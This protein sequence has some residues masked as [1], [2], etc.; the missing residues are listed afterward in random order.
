MKEIGGYEYYNPNPAGRRVGDCTVRAMCKALSLDW[1]PALMLLTAKAVEIYD[2]PSSNAV[3]GALLRDFGF[4]RKTIGV[5]QN[6]PPT[7]STLLLEHPCG[8]VVIAFSGHIATAVDG[9]IYDS[10]DSRNEIPL[11]FYERE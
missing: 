10:W 1:L 3:S 8:T 2:M 9:V 6:G 11:Y 7:A 4:E 5:D